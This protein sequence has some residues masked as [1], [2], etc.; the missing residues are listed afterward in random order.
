MILV[1]ETQIQVDSEDIKHQWRGPYQFQRPPNP[2]FV[3]KRDKKKVESKY[4]IDEFHILSA[5][6]TETPV[7]LR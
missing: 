7:F 3:E 1:R 4:E 2:P 5:R 6:T